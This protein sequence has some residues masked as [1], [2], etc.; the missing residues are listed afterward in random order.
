[1]RVLH[2]RAA[3]VE[4]LED[5]GAALLLGQRD[6]FPVRV[7]ERE[8]RGRRADR[9][10]VRVGDREEERERERHRESPGVGNTCTY[11]SSCGPAKRTTTGPAAS[12]SIGESVST[13]RSPATPAVAL[14]PADSKASEGNTSA[15]VM[16]SAAS[17]KLSTPTGVGTSAMARVT[18]RRS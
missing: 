7:R 13:I 5:D 12:E 6:G 18:M 14:P 3:G 1:V 10:G 2:E 11:R 16:P 8:V 4:P 9:R 15:C 17:G